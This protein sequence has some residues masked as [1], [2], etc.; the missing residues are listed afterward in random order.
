[1]AVCL[2]WS[3]A[4]KAYDV[5]NVDLNDPKR[6]VLG[7]RELTYLSDNWLRKTTLCN[8][9]EFTSEL[10]TADKKEELYAAASK[11]AFWDY[12][13]TATMTVKCKKD[14]QVVRAFAGLTNDN[15][16]LFNADKLMS[17]PEIVDRVDSDDIEK[18]FE[19][20]EAFTLAVAEVDQL[21]YAAR[22]DYGST[23]TFAPPSKEGSPPLVDSSGSVIVAKSTFLDQSRLAVDKMRVSLAFI[24][25][26]L[27][28]T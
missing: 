21:S 10:L 19:S 25:E 24:V 14:P 7:L 3:P 22:T 28:L 26:A 16:L 27:K 1:M 9:G 15:L 12:D 18:Y 5:V 17:K 8:F 20:V 2:L 4:A 11:A 13:K 23:E 6:L